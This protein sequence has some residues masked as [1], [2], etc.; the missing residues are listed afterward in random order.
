MDQ[1]HPVCVSLVGELYCS[2]RNTSHPR[3][4]QE[5]SSWRYGFNMDVCQRI[6][7]QVLQTRGEICSVTTFYLEKDI[8]LIILKTCLCDV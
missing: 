8:V 3:D 1:Y 4:I 5:D 2:G 7:S 6:T